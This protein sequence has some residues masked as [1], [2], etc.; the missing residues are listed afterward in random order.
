[1]LT[2]STSARATALIRPDAVEMVT[3]KRM[4]EG[5]DDKESR[6]ENLWEEDLVEIERAI[7]STRE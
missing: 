4:F 7:E 5:A 3:K 2:D 6:L 1:M